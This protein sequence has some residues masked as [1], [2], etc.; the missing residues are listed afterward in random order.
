MKKLDKIL[1]CIIGGALGDCI[2]GP[3]EGQQMPV[4]LDH[5][6]RWN[7]SDDTQM[8]LATCEAI[9][10]RGYVDPSAIASVLGSWFKEKRITGVGASTLKALSELNIGG[11][12]ALVGRKGEMGAGNGAAM[13]IAPLAFCLNPK[14]HKARVLIRDVC[15]ITHHN[16]EAYVGALAVALSV[17]AACEEAWTGENNLI[18]L[19]IE[20]LPDSSVRDRLN[21][22]AELDQGVS[23]QGAAVRFGCSSYVVESIPFVLFGVQRIRQLGFPAL[24]EEVIS[25]GG[26]TDTNASIAGQII[27]T[28]I[29]QAELPHQMIDRVPNLNLINEIAV[30]FSETVATAAVNQTA[31]RKQ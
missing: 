5:Q 30:E 31:W 19:V 18:R 11:H 4:K 1:G 12:W 3:Y 8:T 15:R 10:R 23:I 24:L 17:H 9:S 2:G 21:E 22:I 14:D 25:C 13:R 6:Q 20:H 7:L 29:G 27:G 26:D 16:E 28:L